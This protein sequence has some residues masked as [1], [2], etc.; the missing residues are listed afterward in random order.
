M[1]AAG[2]GT[3]AGREFLGERRI[4]RARRIMPER[5]AAFPAAGAV[6]F[7]HHHLA[8][9]GRRG[10]SVR[11][12][13]FSAWKRSARCWRNSMTPCVPTKYS[14]RPTTTSSRPRTRRNSSTNARGA[15]GRGPRSRPQHRQRILQDHPE[16]PDRHQ[17]RRE[18]SVMCSHGAGPPPSGPRHREEH[19][20]TPPPA[21]HRQ[22]A[23]QQPAEH[24]GQGAAR[25]RPARAHRLRRPSVE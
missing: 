1:Q 22:A 17:L 13:P 24:P 7:S 11:T 6:S 23:R 21:A 14:P 8:A 5:V 16:P 25:V 15:G 4:I 18:P 9:R 19:P 10:S 2:P 12:W 20:G 3:P